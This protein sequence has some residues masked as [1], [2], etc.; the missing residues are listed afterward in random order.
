MVTQPN[1]SQLFARVGTI[2]ALLLAS[3]N[4][5]QA[6]LL[7]CGFSDGKLYDIN[8]ST[9]AATNPR[10]LG[11]GWGL[12]FSPGG[13]LYGVTQGGGTPAPNTLYTVNPTTGASLPVAV[14]APSIGVE[15]DIAMDPTSGILYAVDGTG[16]L[17]KINTLTGVG[18]SVGFVPGALD[19]SA[20]AFD[21]NG[22]LY[23]VDTNTTKLLRV[24]KFNASVFSSV[25]LVP[26]PNGGV[27]GLAFDPANGTCYLASGAG[28]TN[29]LYKVTPGTGAMQLVGALAGTADGLCALTFEPIPSAFTAFCF[30]DGIGPDADC[31]CGNLGSTGRGC[32]NSASTGGAKLTGA[33]GAFLSFDTMQLTSTGE[34]PSSLSIFLQ[35]TTAIVP[36]Y[37]GDGLRCAGGV[38]KR[39]YTKNAV[40]GTVIA[41]QGSD[42]TISSRSAALGDPIP[43]GATR[44]YQ[45]YYRD[46]SLTFCPSLPGDTFNI[47][48]A[49][50]VAWGT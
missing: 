13:T 47:S 16:F 42:P 35:G 30:G 23:I 3:S 27:A 29:N 22:N 36:T 2:A 9:G 38:L 25:N 11:V 50:A 8:T 4:S 48:N 1:S 41:P 43:A 39:L 5:A 20:L 32:Q 24:N 7:G 10:N 40:A 45:V 31:P 26:A 12:A 21:P 28:T 6:G 18:T 49:I 34:L 33:G 17:F 19:L 37:F 46:P 14:T 44:V 15:G